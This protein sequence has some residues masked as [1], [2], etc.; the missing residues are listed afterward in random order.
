MYI[1][2]VQLV[3]TVLKKNQLKNDKQ[4]KARIVFILLRFNS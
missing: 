4:N 1:L 2:L 3:D